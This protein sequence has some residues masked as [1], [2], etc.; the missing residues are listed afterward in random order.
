MSVSHKC[1]AILR[2]SVSLR[3]MLTVSRLFRCYHHS[4]SAP[5][6]LC[7]T[8]FTCRPPGPPTTTARTG[9]LL[10]SEDQRSFHILSP[11]DRREARLGIYRGFSSS[12]S[13]RGDAIGKIESKHYQLVYTCKVVMMP[14]LGQ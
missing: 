13:V 11:A 8:G 2:P 7:A 12:S 5:S 6:G 10:S 4:R 1:F 9:G 14:V 3:T